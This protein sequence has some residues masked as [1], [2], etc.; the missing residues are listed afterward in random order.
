MDDA[1]FDRLCRR[2]YAGARTGVPDC[3][4]AFD[5]A[6]SVLES[7]PADAD[8]TELALL[9]IDCTEAGRPRMAALARA[10]LEAAGFE[11]GFADEPG[12]LVHLEDAMRLVNRDV[13]AS[14][15]PHA[16]R[17]HVRDDELGLN[18]N[19]YAESWDGE[20]GTGTGVYPRSGADSV[21]ALVAVAEDTQDAV[22]HTLWSAWPVCP[23]HRRGVHA[24]QHGEAGVWWCGSEGGHVVAAIGA[25]EDR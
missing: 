12:W 6:A 19:A 5:L 1:D 14:G 17:L 13:A 16:C 24:R 7:S 3:T 11:P 23:V 10:V 9:S 21:S 4:D 20:P 2:V 18:G 8:A 25:W 15:L 22:M